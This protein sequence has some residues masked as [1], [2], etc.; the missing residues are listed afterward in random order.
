LGRHDAR[1]HFFRRLSRNLLADDVALFG[2]DGDDYARSGVRTGR[3]IVD[4]VIVD[5]NISTRA[6]TSVWQLMGNMN[7]PPAY[8]KATHLLPFI[9]TR[10][11]VRG[12]SWSVWSVDMIYP[13][14]LV[15]PVL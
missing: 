1:Y 12:A 11:S 13:A 10:T 7:R 5:I 15:V 4:V 14:I 3:R 8:L 2:G 9:S 6:R